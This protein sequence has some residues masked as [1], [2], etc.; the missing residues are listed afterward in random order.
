MHPSELSRK[1]DGTKKPD[2]LRIRNAER[3]IRRFKLAT[4]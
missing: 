3:R 4:G 1:S 2:N